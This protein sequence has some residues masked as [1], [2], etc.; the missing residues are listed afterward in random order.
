ML[1]VLFG[2]VF[3]EDTAVACSGWKKTRTVV[4]DTDGDTQDLVNWS[5]SGK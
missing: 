4:V 5:V 1:D 2:A 3:G